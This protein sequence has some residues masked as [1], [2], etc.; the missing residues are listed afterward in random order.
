MVEPGVDFDWHKTNSRIW[1]LFR[2]Y[3]YVFGRRKGIKFEGTSYTDEY[4]R[5]CKVTGTWENVFAV[6]EDIVRAYVRGIFPKFSI[7][8]VPVLQL[9]LIQSD[10]LWQQPA[11]GSPYRYA[12]AFD[13]SPSATGASGVITLACTITGSNPYLFGADAY[14][15]TGSD[16]TGT[17]NGV[18][19][20]ATP[21]YIWVGASNPQN[22]LYLAGPATGTHNLVTSSNAQ[23]LVA[24]SYSG[25]DQGA[26]L[27]N[28]NNH[29]TGTADIPVTINEATANSWVVAFVTGTN[30]TII[31]G[32]GLTVRT[33]NGGVGSGI[34]AS[35]DSNGNVATGSVT[36]HASLSGGGGGGQTFGII[37]I[38]FKEAAAATVVAGG[39]FTA[40]MQS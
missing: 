30:G 35:L 16:I 39:F 17:F 5:T 14:S 38:K 27:A 18:S 25:C 20:G 28:A 4:G 19:M 8:K 11:W 22:A 32:T 34:P 37:G 36:Y 40:M 3:E 23:G 29:V 26:I 1:Q 7:V 13:A 31:G 21:G 9:A 24:N 6:F 2:M 10:P 15:N 12:I 33:N